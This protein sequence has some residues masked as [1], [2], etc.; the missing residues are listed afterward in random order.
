MT[1]RLKMGNRYHATQN[2]EVWAGDYET[3][4]KVRWSLARTGEGVYQLVTD[5]PNHAGSYDCTPFCELCAG[6]QEVAD[7]NEMITTSERC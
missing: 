1:T 6:E 7:C 5:C 3:A 4:L 2:G